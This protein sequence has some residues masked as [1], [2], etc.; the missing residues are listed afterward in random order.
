[1]NVRDE[2]QPIAIELLA[3]FGAPATLV[4]SSEAVSTYDPVTDRTTMVPGTESRRTVQ[5]VILDLEWRDDE[6]REVTQ[7][8]ALMVEKPQTG[9]RLLMGDMAYT[10]GL[11]RIEAPQGQ[12]IYHEAQVS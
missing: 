4:R 2:F 9:D 3:E 12:A 8:T 5:A 1:M 11:V 10:I 6:G 7:A